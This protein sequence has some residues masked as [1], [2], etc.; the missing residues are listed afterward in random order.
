[1]RELVNR[2]QSDRASGI[3]NLA[4]GLYLVLSLTH[5]KISSIQD[6]TAR[7]ESPLQNKIGFLKASCSTVHLISKSRYATRLDLQ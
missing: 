7:R 2:K 5:R 1:M 3:I 6:R 4:Y